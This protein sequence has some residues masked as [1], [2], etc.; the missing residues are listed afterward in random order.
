[1][2]DSFD[3]RINKGDTDNESRKSLIDEFKNKLAESDINY[4]AGTSKG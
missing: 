1:M 3:K 2:T 4:Y